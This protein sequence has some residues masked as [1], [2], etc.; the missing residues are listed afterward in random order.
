MIPLYGANASG[1]TVLQLDDTGTDTDLGSAAFTASLTS[2]PFDGGNASGY[3]TLRRL[4]QIVVV[5]SSATV[6]VT[7]TGDGSDYTGQAY[8]KNLVS[9]GGVE[10]VVEA[11]VQVPGTRFQ[12]KVQVTAHVGKTELG[13][14][15]MWFVGRRTTR[16]P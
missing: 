13:E 7:P 12:M 8:T 15:D 14:A 6:V 2:A 3:E 10:Q 9:T 5:G 16:G 1:N 11:P 4:V